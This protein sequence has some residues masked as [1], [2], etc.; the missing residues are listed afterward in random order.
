MEYC[1]R[2]NA[3]TVTS[4]KQSM[5]LTVTSQGQLPKQYTDS[6]FHASLRADAVVTT[7][8]DLV[9]IPAKMW[10]GGELMA[11]EIAMELLSGSREL[12]A[13]LEPWAGPPTP[14]GQ[15][16]GRRRE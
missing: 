13:L 3:K 6:A 16:A 12:E 8:K 1:Y 7:L 5:A 15:P 9:K 14:P 2:G 11:V 4:D 10:P